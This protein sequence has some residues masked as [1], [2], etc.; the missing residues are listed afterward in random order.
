[1]GFELRGAIPEARL[2]VKSVSELPTSLSAE[3]PDL[4]WA[5][6]NKLGCSASVKGFQNRLCCTCLLS[7][8]LHL[9]GGPAAFFLPER[10]A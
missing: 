9:F 8:W 1:M 2:Q 6:I 10:K 3:I 4:T 7:L 5:G